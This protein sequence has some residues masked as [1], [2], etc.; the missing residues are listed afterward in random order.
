MRNVM[1]LPLVSVSCESE[2]HERVCCL[3]GS[4]HKIVC[5]LSVHSFLSRNQHGAN[6]KNFGADQKTCPQRNLCAK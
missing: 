1:K 3:R 6:I 2:M 4:F 5:N